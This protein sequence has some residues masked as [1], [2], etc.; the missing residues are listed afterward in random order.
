MIRNYVLLAFSATAV[1]FFLHILATTTSNN[2][3]YLNFDGYRNAGDAMA[4]YRADLSDSAHKSE[5]SMNHMHNFGNVME[6]RNCVQ[7]YILEEFGYDQVSTFLT[8]GCD[9]AAIWD[10]DRW[11]SRRCSTEPLASERNLNDPVESSVHETAAPRHT[12]LI[13]T[14]WIGS[15]TG[16][17]QEICALIDSFL[18]THDVE[19]GKAKFTLWLFEVPRDDVHLGTLK[20]LYNFTASVRFL[21]GSEHDLARGTCL[22]GNTDYLNVTVSA[23]DRHKKLSNVMGPKEKA[24]MLRLLILHKYGGLWVDTDSI[25]LRNLQNVLEYF[26]EFAAKVTMAPYYNNNVLGLRRGSDTALKLIDYVCMTPYSRDTRRYCSIVGAPCYPKWY[27]NHGVIQMAVRDRLPLV[28]I[29]WSYTDPAYGCYPPMLL[30]G[31][32]GQRHGGSLEDSLE[33][34]RGAFVLHTRG[35]NAAKP[36]TPASNYGRLYHGMREKVKQIAQTQDWSA[37][38]TEHAGIKHLFRNIGPRNSSERQAFQRAVQARGPNVI[39]PTFVPSGNKSY[40]RIKSLRFRGQCLTAARPVSMGDSPELRI[41]ECTKRD[42]I[43]LWLYHWI[44]S[45]TEDD[46]AALS[47]GGFS[48]SGYLR[49]A[50]KKLGGGMWGRIM[51]AAGLPW[52]SH[53]TWDGAPSLLVCDPQNP[54]MRWRVRHDSGQIE[55]VG[56][57]TCVQA[58]N[59]SNAVYPAPRRCQS[60]T[61]VGRSQKWFFETVR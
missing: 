57:G 30:S 53:D 33:M 1:F 6:R 17:F 19:D 25:I 27:W 38:T 61:Q 39:E 24:D 29:P 12:L 41:Q 14:A 54:S 48:A 18:L 3:M 46:A 10:F 55:N 2:I 56:M 5:K 37:H 28:I 44:Y 49:P 51:C 23:Q 32:G 43:D 36:L 42:D 45:E 35:Y 21:F 11:A 16:I 47:N 20:A 9:R 40:M 31:A 59:V 15:I 34:I 52:H 26:G 22:Q 58:V 60:T 8:P 50:S 7:S 4:S 13:H